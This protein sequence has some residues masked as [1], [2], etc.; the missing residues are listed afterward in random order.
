[1]LQGTPLVTMGGGT[2]LGLFPG[3]EPYLNSQPL[4]LVWASIISFWTV[5]TSELPLHA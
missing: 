3:P 4:T 5:T 1:M 2:E